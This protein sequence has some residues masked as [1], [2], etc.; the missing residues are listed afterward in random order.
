[1]FPIRPSPCRRN[2]GSP[3]AA[4][5]RRTRAGRDAA[6]RAAGPT[7]GTARGAV[8]Q[9]RVRVRPERW[10]TSIEVAAGVYGPQRSRRQR[11]RDVPGR[12]R[13]QGAAARQR[14]RQRHLRRAS[15]STPA[16][17]RT[18]APRSRPG[19]GAQ[20]D[21]QNGRVGNVVDQKGALLG[22]WRAP[23]SHEPRDRQRRV[24]RRRPG[25][26]R[27]AQRVRVLPGAR[28]SRSATRRSATARRWTCSSCAATG[29]AS[30]RTA[31]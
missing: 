20:R 14:R 2:S 28:G 21:L 7:A 24:P 16:G 13:Q 11:A 27:G 4:A 6:R 18:A 25:R 19:E 26:R 23:A 9:L 8:R 15:T 22:G 10:A 5:H 1:M 17:H 31:A 12:R 29:G 30:R 3:P